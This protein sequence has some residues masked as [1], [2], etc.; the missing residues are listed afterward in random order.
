MITKVI[1]FFTNIF[2]LFFLPLGRTSSVRTWTTSS[3]H[4]W[5]RSLSVSMQAF[6]RCAAAKF[7]SFSSQ[8]NCRPWWS[9]TPT[10]TGRSSKRSWHMEILLLL[11]IVKL[12]NVIFQKGI[13]SLYSIGWSQNNESN[14]A[15]L[16]SLIFKLHT[17]S[18]SYKKRVSK[19]ADFCFH[20]SEYWIQ[21]GVLGRP[22]HHQTLLGS[23]PQSSFRKEETIPLWVL[24]CTC[25]V[26]KR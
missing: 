15:T 6:T 1:L 4:Q 11:F 12:D 9:A 24:L 13:I 10:T 8:T 21:R 7:W 20:S 2:L 14:V 16:E 22:S 5:L 23:V 26:L 19:L 17:N 18:S 3:T 25:D